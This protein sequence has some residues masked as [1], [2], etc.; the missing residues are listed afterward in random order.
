MRQREIQKPIGLIS[1]RTILHVH[2]TFFFLN[3]NKARRN[4]VP[5]ELI[6]NRNE[7]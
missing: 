5:K 3:L 2:H 6:D 1:K 4:S 7:G